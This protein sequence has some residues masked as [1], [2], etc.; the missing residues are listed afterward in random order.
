MPVTINGSGPVTGAN[1]AL[2]K[3]VATATS[4]SS[5]TGTSGTLA[6]ITGMSLTFTAVAGR[7]YKASFFCSQISGTAGDRVGLG[8]KVNSA[9]VQ[10]A[11]LNMLSNGYCVHVLGLFTASGS[12]TVVVN[13][14]RDV[15]TGTV[16]MYGA[17][18]API[19]LLIEDIGAA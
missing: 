17:S 16:T 11:Y 10:Q 15:G 3:S 8:I 14:I 6:Q 9:D 4:T 12:T 13:A 18:A 5:Y 19:T 2:G 7:Q 1:V